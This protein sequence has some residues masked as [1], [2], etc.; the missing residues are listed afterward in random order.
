MF[1]DIFFSNAMEMQVLLRI[2]MSVE[3]SDLT[4][5]SLKGCSDD[6]GHSDFYLF[7]LHF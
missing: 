3:C 5:F 2:I 6:W 4:A 7:F 1:I